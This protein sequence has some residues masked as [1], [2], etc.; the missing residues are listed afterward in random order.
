MAI[1]LVTGA[2][3]GLGRA[4][5]RELAQRGW[6][7]VID[8]RHGDTLA[9]AERAILASLAPDASLVAVAGDVTDAEHRRALVEAAE[10]LGGLDLVVNNA[11]SLGVTPLP[12]LVGYPLDDLTSVFEV[13]VVAPLALVQDAMSLLHRSARPAVINI[14]SDAS[15]EAYEGW[16]GYG[17]SKAALDHM[18]AVMAVEEPTVLVW[19]VDPGD[20]RTQMHQDAFPGED[21]SDR[22]LPEDVVA[23]LVGLVEAGPPSGRYRLADLRSA[24]ELVLETERS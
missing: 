16:G 8:A 15:V 21:I 2:S 20:M 14:T 18:S 4:L 11:S 6:C 23:D 1:A 13:N 22:P 9:E 24:R 19:A 7:L 10:R 12:N 5:A 17:L 3:K